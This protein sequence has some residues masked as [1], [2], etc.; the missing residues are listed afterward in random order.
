MSKATIILGSQFGDECKNKIVDLLAAKAAYVC[1][2]N[3]GYNETHTVTFNETKY[4]FRMIPSAI[5]N[6][7]CISILGNGCVIHLPDLLKE[8]NK[9]ET[10]G[11][12][13][14]KERLC[15]SDRAH[16]VFDF[17][18]QIDEL[19]KSQRGKE[20]FSMSEKGIGPAYAFKALRLIRI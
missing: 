14:L 13:N 6:D 5:R 18:K 20:C 7:S 16:L 10:M 11:I 19:E 17:H 4:D 1:H 8:I 2:F 3:S 15:I 12:K 9:I